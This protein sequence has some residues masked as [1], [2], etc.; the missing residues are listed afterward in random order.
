[1]P[2]I[3][4]LS[5]EIPTSLSVLPGNIGSTTKGFTAD[6][7]VGFWSTAQGDMPYAVGARNLARL[8]PPT[9]GAVMTYSSASSVP[10]WT[11]GTSGGVLI[12][13]TLGVPSWLAVGTSGQV[14]T[15]STA[16][17][18]LPTWSTTPFSAGSTDLTTAILPTQVFS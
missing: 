12:V 13:S 17:T 5:T 10:A 16:G 3:S 15:A 18:G 6:Q 7:L 8:A 9:S 2:R 11:I 4:Q 14:L 1:M